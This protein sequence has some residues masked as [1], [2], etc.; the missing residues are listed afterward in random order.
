MIQ[1][2]SVN[3]KFEF[4]MIFLKR[5]LLSLLA[6][7]MLA[8]LMVYLMPLNVQVPEMERALIGVGVASRC[9]MR[10]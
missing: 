9:W 10:T 7:L 4:C 8:M 6:L 3:K 5:L 1:S 2:C